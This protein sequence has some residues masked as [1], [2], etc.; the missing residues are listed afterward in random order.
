MAAGGRQ[1]Q[2]RSEDETCKVCP[3]VES[4][5][6]CRNSEPNVF[7]V[8]AERKVITG[9]VKDKEVKK[10]KKKI[11][12]D[13]EKKV[14]ALRN[15]HGGHLL[16][17]L[18]GHKKGDRF[19]EY[20]HE[21]VDK[22]LQYLIECGKPYTD[23]YVCTWLCDLDGFEHFVDVLLI[24]V[25]NTCCISTVNFNTK[26]CSDFEKTNASTWNIVSIL[27]HS[28]DR[29]NVDASLRGVEPIPHE[30]RNTELKYLPDQGN[31]SDFDLVDYIWDDL[32][33]KDNLTSLSKV[34]G[35]GSYYVG[36]AENAGTTDG[37]KNKV[38]TKEGFQI[39]NPDTF[40]KAITERI[41]AD[42][43]V[44][45]YRGTFSQLPPSLIKVETYRVSASPKK[46]ILEVAI[47]FFGGLVFSDREGPRTYEISEGRIYRMAK[48]EWQRRITQL[49]SWKGINTAT[50][51]V[52]DL[53]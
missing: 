27:A 28:P 1:P 22:T 31:K 46:Y 44:L 14:S 35:G 42:V 24:T 38:I 47:G 33:L 17:H 45:D 4:A 40:K 6:V 37:Y 3:N 11:L 30:C 26:I 48:E 41:N 18:D 13:I 34:H 50:Q 5:Y 43:C 12:Q 39:T 7:I 10:R 19:L 29:A 51:E 16:V 9:R 25:E 21:F 15:T 23:S 36:L 32:K 20:F 52:R 49:P 53:A 2:I 8:H